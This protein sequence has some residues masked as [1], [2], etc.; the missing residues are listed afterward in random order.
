MRQILIGIP[1]ETHRQLAVA[2][3]EGLKELGFNISTSIYAGKSGYNNPLSRLYIILKNTF[4]IIQRI[5]KDKIELVY[6][7]SSFNPNSVTRDFITLSILRFVDVKKILKLHGSRVMLLQ[8]NN[9]VFRFMINKIS[10]WADGFG[11]LS[12]EEKGNF[13]NAGFKSEKLF[14][15]KNI[16]PSVNSP[17]SSTFR[18]DH[19]IAD[20]DKLALYIGRFI[21][22]KRVIDIIRALAIVKRSGYKI[23]LL[24]VGDGPENNKIRQEVAK[25][26]LSES[27][28]FTGYIK[29]EE[30]KIYYA[31]ADMLVFPSLTEGFA[32]AIFTSVAAGLPIITTQ[33]RAAAD[34]LHEPDNCLWIAQENPAMIAEKI[35][36]LLKNPAV[37]NKM[38]DNN[39]KLS[40]SFSQKIIS[41]ELEVI[42]NQFLTL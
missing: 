21:P 15:V 35:I 7:N 5:R 36:Y 14:V 13:I 10:R 9:I 28:I 1:E 8:S 17:K 37:C 26:D 20:D 23:K 2:E 22:S 30:T 39:R 27:V 3:V 33:I 18:T 41:L 25:L 19:H 24:C 16:V 29:E 4:T 32:M 12:S 31:N 42:F 34:Y 40:K 6:L 11:V 38:S